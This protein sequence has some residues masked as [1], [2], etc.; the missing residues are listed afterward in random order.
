[1]SARLDKVQFH[2]NDA[3]QCIQGQCDSSTP[4]YIALTHLHLHLAVQ[5]LLFA[6]RELTKDL[7]SA[8]KRSQY[9]TLGEG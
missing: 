1:M 8:A 3:D 2:L 5:E 6:V 9:C 7:P 4:E